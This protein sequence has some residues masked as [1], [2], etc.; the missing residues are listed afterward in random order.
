M[1]NKNEKR[2]SW[3]RPIARA[4]YDGSLKTYGE[5]Q[6]RILPKD[7]SEQYD[8]SLPETWREQPVRWLLR[9]LGK[10]KLPKGSGAGYVQS[11]LKL[12]ISHF[13]KLRTY[14]Q[15]KS[16]SDF[17]VVKFMG[18]LLWLI[19]IPFSRISR[20]PEIPH[21]LPQSPRCSRC[22]T[23][24]SNFRHWKRIHNKPPEQKNSRIHNTSL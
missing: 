1:I 16:P 2:P 5:I 13:G 8:V 22:H 3:W 6:S 10:E 9:A 19:G 14:T 20:P 4:K 11:P 24:A 21:H 7:E 12:R 23:Q 18:S 15:W 17:F